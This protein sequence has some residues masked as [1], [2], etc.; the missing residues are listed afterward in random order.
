MNAVL[1]FVPEEDRV[2]FSSITGQSLYYMGEATLAHRVLALAEE[3]GAKRA[4]YA[5]KL[6]QSE[7]ELRIASTGKD[8]KTGSLI[9][10]EYRVRGPVALLMT[11]TAV[12]IDPE[13]QNRCLVL[14]VD[15]SRET[16]REIHRRQRARRTLAALADAGRRVATIQRHQ[17]SQRLLRPLAVVNPYAEGLSFPDGSTRLRRDHEKYLK[18][19]DAIAL[20]HQHQRETKTITVDGKTLEY[21]E[22][23]REDIR[24][25][26]RLAAVVLGR[27]VDELPPQTRRLLS[28]VTELVQGEAK[29]REIPTHELRFTR[30]ELRERLAWGDTQLKVHLARLVEL[31]YLIAHRVTPGRRYVYEL[32]FEGGAE[33]VIFPGLIHPDTLRAGEADPRSG[34]GR[35]SV[36]ARSG[37]GRASDPS[38]SADGR[39]GIQLAAPDT[40][41]THVQPIAG[42]AS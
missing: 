28:L 18:L 42:E 19:I 25:A 21:V 13:L 34:D 15:E 35:A 37:H 4:S 7:G 12:E 39:E 16:T 36:G 11:T 10:Q 5:L 17:A 26:N 30:R 9:A 3:E 33:G 32:A 41:A 6:L 2:Q 14:A 24:L 20:L 40:L 31:E 27:S 22:V 29:T 38:G 8:T 23:T 1:D